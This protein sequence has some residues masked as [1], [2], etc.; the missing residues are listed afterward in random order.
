MLSPKSINHQS[1]FA[2][3]VT[4]SLQLGVKADDGELQL[5]DHPHIFVIG[6]AADAFGARKSGS[7]A[8]DQVP[9]SSRAFEIT[10][11]MCPDRRSK[12]SGILSV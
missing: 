4:P 6:D 7:A 1:G 11:L 3:Y 2:A 5:S 12:P 8:W 10:L 9:D